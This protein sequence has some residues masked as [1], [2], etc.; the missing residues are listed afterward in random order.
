[1]SIIVFMIFKKFEN[2]IQK[3]SKG[4]LAFH[5]NLNP[6]SPCWRRVGFWRPFAEGVCEEYTAAYLSLKSKTQKIFFLKIS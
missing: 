1:M 6:S 2:R 5:N 4:N 3:R